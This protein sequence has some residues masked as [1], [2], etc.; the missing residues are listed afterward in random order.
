MCRAFC[1]WREV[2]QPDAGVVI[3]RRLYA[4][5]FSH[6]APD[7]NTFDPPTTVAVMDALEQW[8]AAYGMMDA[9]IPMT[10]AAALTEEAASC[11]QSRAAGHGPWYASEAGVTARTKVE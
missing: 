7:G 1:G 3:A 6:D 9:R 10:T 2:D 8:T 5:R 4:E 11:A